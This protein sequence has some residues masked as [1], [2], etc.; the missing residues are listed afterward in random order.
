M[1]TFALVLLAA[2]ICALPARAVTYAMWV[3][4]TARPAEGYLDT[5][6]GDG[7]GLGALWLGGYRWPLT[8]YDSWWHGGPLV[9][10]GW[11][12]CVIIHPFAP[13]IVGTILWHGT[14]GKLDFLSTDGVWYEFTVEVEEEIKP[15]LAEAG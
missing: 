1:K 5:D 6:I 10:T 9:D 8:G 11:H 3:G 12:M 14:M 13:W 15:Q 4:G 7:Q 2:L